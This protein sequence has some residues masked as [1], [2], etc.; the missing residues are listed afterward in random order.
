MSEGFHV[1]PSCALVDS[2]DTQSPPLYSQ[3]SDAQ[4]TE[5]IVLHLMHAQ[6]AMGGIDTAQCRLLAGGTLNG[7]INLYQKY[8]ELELGQREAALDQRIHDVLRHYSQGGSGVGVAAAP[9]SPAPA[10]PLLA[11]E[12]L[13][14][15]VGA[16]PGAVAAPAASQQ[17]ARAGRAPPIQLNGGAFDG[18]RGLDA[19][20]QEHE[21]AADSLSS[22]AAPP[23]LL[24]PPLPPSPPAHCT[25]PPCPSTTAR[26]PQHS[27]C[28]RT[29]KRVSFSANCSHDPSASPSP[30]LAADSTSPAKRARCSLYPHPEEAPAAAGS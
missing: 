7:V 25:P 27:S 14:P 24:Q 3:L 26:R 4:H 18:A 11:F 15:A 23:A 22:E 6:L 16:R 21:Q 5:E 20:Q 13:P 12:L 30:A 1:D 29:R 9:H 10:P 8:Y 28:L 17:A 19:A 2:D